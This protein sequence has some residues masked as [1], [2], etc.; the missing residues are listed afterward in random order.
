MD[1]RSSYEFPG[2]PARGIA[3]NN[4]RFAETVPDIETMINKKFYDHN[5]VLNLLIQYVRAREVNNLSGYSGEILDKFMSYI[6]LVDSCIFDED[7]RARFEAVNQI[8]IDL[9]PMMQRCFDDLRDK[10]QQAQQN[11]QQQSAAAAGSGN[12]SGSSGGSSDDDS[13]D[14]GTEA[15]KEALESQLPKF[16]TFI[17]IANALKVDAN[18]LLRDVLDVSTSTASSEISEKLAA[19]PTDEQR[20]IMRILD[21][22]INEE[23]A[24]QS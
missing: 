10:K 19:L 12:G 7:A 17:S 8:M 16:E 3:L 5:I 1:A 14:A 24:K 4:L 18:T 2:T 20:K 22:M 6:P 21:V 23:N 9:W 11:Q 13:K 15:I